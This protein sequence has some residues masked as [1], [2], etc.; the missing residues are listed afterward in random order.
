MRHW[1]EINLRLSKLIEIMLEG[2]SV[3]KVSAPDIRV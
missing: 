2:V 1:I 3:I